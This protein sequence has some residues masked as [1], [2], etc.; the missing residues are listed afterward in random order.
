MRVQFGP[1]FFVVIAL[2]T[3]VLVGVCAGY[4]ALGW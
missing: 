3:V 4:Y 1:R 2:W